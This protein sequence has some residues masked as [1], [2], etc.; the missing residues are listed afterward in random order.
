MREAKGHSLSF[1]MW[2]RDCWER[3]SR[4]LEKGTIFQTACWSD[5]GGHE[6]RDSIYYLFAQNPRSVRPEFFCCTAALFICTNIEGVR[7]EFSAVRCIKYLHSFR[8]RVRLSLLLYGLLIFAQISRKGTASLLLYGLH[9]LAL[10]SRRCTA[11]LLLYSCIYY[12]HRNR[13][14]CTAALLGTNFQIL[15]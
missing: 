9:L 7:P 15:R 12:R 11:C 1:F 10:F 3:R 14:G 2:R 4:Q 8:G 13:E 5:F 6:D